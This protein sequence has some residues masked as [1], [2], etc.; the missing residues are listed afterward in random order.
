MTDNEKFYDDEIAPALLELAN[1]MRPRGM[2]MVATVEYDRG[3]RGST[4]EL[5]KDRGF[6]MDLLHALSRAGNHIDSF[7][8][9]VIRICNSRGISMRE[10]IFL[11]SYGEDPR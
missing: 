3:D 7:L 4:C 10:S 6:E 9:A 5:A 2:S 11:K 1:K 8:I